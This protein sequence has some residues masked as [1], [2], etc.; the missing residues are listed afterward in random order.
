MSESLVERLRKRA[1][2]RRKVTCRGPEDRLSKDLEDA[3]D[4]IDEL[5]SEVQRLHEDAAG[6][7]L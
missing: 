4:K 3:A 1:A 6:S 7:S 5:E 2:I